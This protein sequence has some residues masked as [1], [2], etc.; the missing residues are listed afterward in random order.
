MPS[1]LSKWFLR[2]QAAQQ[3]RDRELRA[4]IE[5]AGK[6]GDYTLSCWFESP[7]SY[8][9]RWPDVFSPAI[10]TRLDSYLPPGSLDGRYYK[11][12]YKFKHDSLS[13]WF[14]FYR[15]FKALWGRR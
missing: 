12:A 9:S 5:A 15:K 14:E 11:W 3:R 4:E 13:E 1:S 7:M 2:K 8:P 6:P 10:E